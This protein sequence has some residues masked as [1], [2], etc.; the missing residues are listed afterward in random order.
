ME[1][2]STRILSIDSLR[3]ELEKA[4]EEKKRI[5][6]ANGAFDLFHI[7]HL[8]YLQG[9]RVL[10]DLLVVAVNS[11]LS[12]RNL[13]GPSRPVVDQGSRALIVASLRCVDYVVLFDES[14]V[15]PL[16][17]TLRPHVHAKG[18][19]YTVDTVPE[20]ETSRSLGIE[21]AICGGPRITSSTDVITRIR[22]VYADD[23]RP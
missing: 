11:D 14:T 19:D 9:A 13:K 18:S 1:P 2:T 10:G 15:E 3:L 12:V 4:R 6:L 17:R 20:R 21:T 5:V 16:L 22:R 8:R 23:R 7:G